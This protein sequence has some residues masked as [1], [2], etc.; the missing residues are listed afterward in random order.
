[1]A[2]F[3]ENSNYK[4]IYWNKICWLFTKSFRS[5]NGLFSFK[6]FLDHELIVNK[7]CIPKDEAYK[8]FLNE[9]PETILEKLKQCKKLLDFMKNKNKD[10]PDEINEFFID[11]K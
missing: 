3:K 1:M 7:R 9:D 4:T 8:D 5:Y 6:K 2:I 11:S 10:I